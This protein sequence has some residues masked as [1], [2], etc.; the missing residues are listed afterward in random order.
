[1][2]DRMIVQKALKRSWSFNNNRGQMA[3]NLA[4]GQDKLTSLLVYDI[5]GG[6]I[7]KTQMKKG[8][9]FHNRIDGESIDFTE[10]ETEKSSKDKVWMDQPSSPDEIYNYIVDEDYSS[11]FTRFIR[12][13][14]EAVGLEKTILV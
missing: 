3:N 14:E 6:E 9:H 1:M 12:A 13:Y 11:L 7:L 2:F 4:D 8:W 10:L 5:F